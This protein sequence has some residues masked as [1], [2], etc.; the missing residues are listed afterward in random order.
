VQNKSRK[1]VALEA[2]RFLAD[3]VETEYLHAKERAISALGLSSQTRLPSNRKIKDCVGLIT[4]EE[5]GT[6]EVE[7]RLTEMRAI[8]VEIMALLEDF[9]PFL[10]GSVLTGAISRNSDIDLHAY[11]DEVEILTNLLEDFGFEDLDVEH[12]ENRKGHF[13]HIKWSEKSYPVEITVYPWSWRET[14]FYSSVTGKPMRRAT[15]ESLVK[16]TKTGPR[17]AKRSHKS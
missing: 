14:V 12:V 6:Q 10:I 4:R 11:C 1:R 7:R 5:L 2:A 16:L 8:A 9:D 13:V 15:L 17:R 3:G